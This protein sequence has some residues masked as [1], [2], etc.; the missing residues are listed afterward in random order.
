M[1]SPHSR[2]FYRT[3]R[4]GLRRGIYA[5]HEPEVGRETFHSGCDSEV[6]HIRCGH[7]IFFAVLLENDV[8]R[9]ERNNL[10]TDGSA[11]EFG[12]RQH[13][14]DLRLQ[15]RERLH[16]RCRSRSRRRSWIRRN[17]DRRFW[18]RSGR[19]L[20][21]RSRRRFR[22]GAFSV[23]RESGESRERKK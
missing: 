23:L 3:A 4:I 22:R 21:Y 6:F 5:R 10:N 14:L 16:D 2:A 18:N 19:W 20:K 15:V 7:H 11:T 1:R 17:N 8:S 13:R 9:I 12:P